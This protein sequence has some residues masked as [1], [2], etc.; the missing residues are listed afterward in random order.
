MLSRGKKLVL[1]TRPTSPIARDEPEASVSPSNTKQDSSNS[2]LQTLNS[3]TSNAIIDDGNSPVEQQ[4]ESPTGDFSGTDSGDDFKPSSSSSSSTSSSSRSSS[5]SSDRTLENEAVNDQEPK[6]SPKKRGRKRT[7][8]PNN[9]KK[10]IAKKLKNS[11]CEYRS[12][13]TGKTVQARKIGPSCTDKCRLACSSH[14]TQEKRIQ[15][16]NSYWELGSV[17]RHRHFLNSCIRPLEIA[18]RR[19][20]TNRRYPR[21]SNSA[22]YL[23]NE[24]NINFNISKNVNGDAIK[25]SEIMSIKFN[26]NCANYQ[27]RT[28]YKTENWE[29]TKAVS[30]PNRKNLRRG[31]GNVPSINEIA[32]KPAYTSK[33]AVTERKQRDLLNLVETNIVPK[34]YEKFFKDLI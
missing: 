8:N 7:R 16:F 17:D 25:V 9:W 32:L 13:T 27:Y 24:D 4:Y 26:K 22:F 29:E 6:L 5:S 1:L 2:V 12:I 28:T 18:S 10:N 31:R 23:L 34:Y 20:K 21:Q 11:G 3:P 15:I 33:I 14:F 30:E 19:I